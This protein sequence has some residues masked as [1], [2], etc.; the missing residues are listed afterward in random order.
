MTLKSLNLY[1]LAT[2]HIAVAITMLVLYIFSFISAVLMAFFWIWF[3]A[4]GLYGIIFLIVFKFKKNLKE[5]SMV[6]ILYVLFFASEYTTLLFLGITAF[7]FCFLSEVT[8]ISMPFLFCAIYASIKHKSYGVK[9]ARFIAILSFTVS[10]ALF[11]LFAETI[12]MILMVNF[13]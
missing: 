4:A 1:L 7:P 9:T 12:D 2:E 6:Y 10:M 3:I 13:K 11:G 8:S 5:S